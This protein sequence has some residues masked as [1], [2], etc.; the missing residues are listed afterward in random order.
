M[1]FRTNGCP[2]RVGV[3]GE[4]LSQP[5]RGHLDPTPD[6]TFLPGEGSSAQRGGL[7]EQGA[8]GSAL[9]APNFVLGKR[10]S[11]V[12]T[13]GVGGP[14]KYFIE[15]SSEDEMCGVLEYCRRHRIRSLVVG[16]GSNCLF[17]DRGFDGCVIVNRIDFVE[18]RGGGVFRAGSGAPFN[19]LGV[20][21]AARGF[22]GLEFAAG[23]P[24]TVGGAVY[25]NAGAN[26]QETAQV[27]E[28][29]EIVTSQGARQMMARERGELVY[30][31]RESPFQSM[32]AGTAVVAATFRLT[33]D[34]GARQLQRSFM[35][36]RRKTQPVLERTA[37]CVFRNPGGGSSSAGAL[38]DQLGLKGHRVGGAQVSEKHANF[39]I[40]SGGSKAS[41]ILALIALVKERV[42]CESGILLQEEILCIPYE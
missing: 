1:V 13:W 20:H 39:V 37:G 32:G 33:A 3:D 17:D 12:C 14:A 11:S 40:N 22:S 21:C 16:R 23:I 36:R 27:L 9:A 18:D 24:G 7:R 5:P 2:P 29:V 10:L 42:E 19:Q 8:D 15:V 6:S 26:G 34:R 28:S 31:Y 30:G 25:M 4:A 38:I 35:D 41:D